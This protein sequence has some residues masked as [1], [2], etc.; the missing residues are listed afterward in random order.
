MCY[1]ALRTFLNTVDIACVGRPR[2]DLCIAFVL[3]PVVRVG[4]TA[5]APGQSKQERAHRADWV[6]F[7]GIKQLGSRTERSPG[8]DDAF[9]EAS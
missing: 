2:E 4:R 9:A 1:R 7:L 8:N 3:T 6:E 5:G